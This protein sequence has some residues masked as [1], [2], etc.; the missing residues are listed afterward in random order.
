MI[1]LPFIF[2]SGLLG[3]SHCI[4]MCGPF[5]LVIGATSPSPRDS[6][7]RQ[8][9]YGAGRVCTYCGLGA[10]AGYLGF[11]FDRAGAGF[12][13]ASA[14]LACVAGGF[15]VYQ[16]LATT[17]VIPRRAKKGETVCAAAPLFRT[18]LTSR[19]RTDVFAAGLFTGFLPC[20]LLYG[21]LALAAGTGSVGRGLLVMGV[22][23]LGTMPL[24]TLTGVSGTL[25]R[26]AARQRLLHLAAWSVV[27]AGALTLG[28]GI[29]QL[30][31]NSVSSAAAACPMC[32]G[33]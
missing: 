13:N 1:E 33:E 32:R 20:G 12:V 3:A 29:H 2:A 26:V 6:L 28:R 11:R 22:F 14:L 31:A 23:G 30:G 15:L 16:G 18:L 21:M 4:G 9:L 19:R 5:A 25:L 17:G 24:M 8:A 27:I 7:M 10:A